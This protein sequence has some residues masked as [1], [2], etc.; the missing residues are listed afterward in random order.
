MHLFIL[1]DKSVINTVSTVPFSPSMNI[2][3]GTVFPEISDGT[4]KV[5]PKKLLSLSIAFTSPLSVELY[6][7]LSPTLN[8]RLLPSPFG[9]L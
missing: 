4:N 5:E 9:L 7:V 3:T 1:F 8:T 6:I 2:R